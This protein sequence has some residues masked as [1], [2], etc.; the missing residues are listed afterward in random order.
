[1]FQFL[2]FAAFTNSSDRLRCVRWSLDKDPTIALVHAFVLSGLLLQYPRRSWLINFSE[3]LMQLH[4][5]SPMIVAWP[6]LHCSIHER[7]YIIQLRVA[8]MVHRC[9]NGL[10]PVY[11]YLYELCIP[12]TQTQ[13]QYYTAGRHSL[14]SWLLRRWS[15]Q[16]D[17]A[18]SFSVSGPAVWNNL[19]DCLRNPASSLTFLNFL[20]AQYTNS[21]TNSALETVSVSALYKFMVELNWFEVL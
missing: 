11:Q 14:I 2:V 12:A 15:R 17:V 4:V 8:V 13:S 6:I 1:M 5:S 10:A 19:P 9:L 21:D 18:R 16:T 7:V 20:F 3:S